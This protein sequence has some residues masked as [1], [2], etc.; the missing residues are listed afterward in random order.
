MRRSIIILFLFSIIISGCSEKPLARIIDG[1]IEIHVNEEFNPFSVFYDVQDGADI[2]YEINENESL[3]S[4]V[5]CKDDREERFDDI[6]VKLIYPDPTE[7]PYKVMAL[8]DLEIHDDHNTNAGLYGYVRKDDVFEVYETFIDGS[9]IWCRISTLHWI[10]NKQT[11]CLKIIPY[12]TNIEIIHNSISFPYFEFDRQVFWDFPG[13]FILTNDPKN[14]DALLS[15]EYDEKGR[16]I[17]AYM[18]SLSPFWKVQYHYDSTGRLER[19]SNG[20]VDYIYDDWGRV[21]K[22]VSGEKKDSFVYHEYDMY[23]NLV[24]VIIDGDYHSEYKNGI[25]V[26]YEY[27]GSLKLEIIAEYNIYHVF[28]YDLDGNEVEIFY[29]N[30]K[31]IRNPIEPHV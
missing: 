29:A 11:S 19:L 22:E 9:D 27:N 1:P 2:S 17:S 7:T 8:K 30:D 24:R 23:N 14:N 20:Y 4:F 25:I 31:D 28:R 26:E 15:K 6:E 12:D 21:A 3:I 10:C 13:Y 18:H 16:L 5:V